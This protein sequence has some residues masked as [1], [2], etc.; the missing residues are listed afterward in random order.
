MAATAGLHLVE[1]WSGFEREPFTESSVR[2][3]S[4]Y[5]RVG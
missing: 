4:V 3:L 2:H 1:R 5:R